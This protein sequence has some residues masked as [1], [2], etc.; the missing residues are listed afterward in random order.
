MSGGIDISFTSDETD[1]LKAQAKLIKQQEE[2]IEKYR[3]VGKEAK[4]AAKDGTKEMEKFAAATTKIN[5]LPAEKYREEMLKLE[6][7][8][9]AGKISQETFNRALGKA[10]EEFLQTGKSATKLGEAVSQTGAAQRVTLGQ[11]AVSGIKN[12][13]LGYASAA[14]AIGIFRGALEQMHAEMDRGKK[15]FEELADQRRNLLQS[16]GPQ[17]YDQSV[18]K[19]DQL[20]A[21]YGIKRP[22]AYELLAGSKKFGYESSVD[23]V[24]GA[25]GANLLSLQSANVMAGKIPGMFPGAGIT[26]QQGIGM[27]LAAT[28][29]TQ[30]NLQELEGPG[31]EAAV[32]VSRLGGTPSE[33]LGALGSLVNRFAS[34]ESAATAITAISRK[35]VA[36]PTSRFAG[37][38]FIGGLDVLA[39]MS[40]DNRAEFLKGRG[41]PAMYQ[42]MAEELGAMRE[43]TGKVEAARIGGG[44]LSAYVAAALDP[45]TQIGRTQL[46]SMGRGRAEVATDIYLEKGAAADFDRER[47]LL[48]AKQ[49][50]R[51]KGWGGPLT[52]YVSGKW[53]EGMEGLEM[54]P[55]A[56]TAFGKAAQYTPLGFVESGISNLVDRLMGAADK[57]DDS[58][59]N[60]SDAT[61]RQRAAAGQQPE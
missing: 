6:K 61:G 46:G 11:Q 57:L 14:T 21:Q 1:L 45:S 5:R 15:S 16:Y 17:Q 47:A 4:D 50:I 55:G 43:R 59:G 58:A 23:M 31:K 56:I 36:D 33:A 26:A 53:M 24:A 2:M 19:A 49:K 25:I 52:R 44:D 22:V 37:K 54:S 48:R 8:L 40:P 30:L 12:L 28:I 27:G 10:R 9:E 34:A 60:L 18:D 20:A 39:G 29:G 35:M 3:K 7:V 13:A 51:E 41:L 32:A 42:P 38:G